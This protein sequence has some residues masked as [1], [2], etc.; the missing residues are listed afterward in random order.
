MLPSDTPS[1]VMWPTCTTTF[2]RSSSSSGLRSPDRCDLAP[3]DVSQPRG[4]SSGLGTT[5]R[6]A[7][8]RRRRTEDGQ[9]VRRLDRS[10]RPASILSVTTARLCCRR[11]VACRPEQGS[12]RPP[13]WNRRC[14][15]RFPE[16]SQLGL[17]HRRQHGLQRGSASGHLR[18][19]ESV[20]AS[21]ARLRQHPRCRR[22]A[23]R[24]EHRFR[25]PCSS[26]DRPDDR[27][28]HNRSDHSR[29]ATSTSK[30][31]Q[32]RWPQSTARPDKS[33]GEASRRV[34]SI[35]PDGVAVGWGK[36]FAATRDGVIA[37]N[38]RTMA[39][40][41]WSRRLDDDSHRGCRYPTDRG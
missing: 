2:L 15:G 5:S 31:I 21:R 41:V 8:T 13:D 24:R 36:V 18:W 32:A 10:G 29:T 16:W 39:T 11:E 12:D 7:D 27:T 37:L 23:H 28:A 20:A 40:P 35:G 6:C 14:L 19:E 1:T 38:V 25:G 33:C 9:L 17:T 34:L 3:W 26:L 30:T 4:A 22:V